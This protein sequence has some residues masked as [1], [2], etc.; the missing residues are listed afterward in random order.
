MCEVLH[1]YINSDHNASGGGAVVV[2]D[3]RFYSDGAANQEHFERGG[4][5][6]SCGLDF[7]SVWDIWVFGEC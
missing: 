7:K 1:E 2:G 4:D 3:Q 5:Y 6:C